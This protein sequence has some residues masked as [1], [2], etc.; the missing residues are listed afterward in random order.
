MNREIKEISISE[1]IEAIKEFFERT[2]PVE[3]NYLRD[4]LSKIDMTGV[5][6]FMFYWHV[7]DSMRTKT[8]PA[9]GVFVELY[10]Q[11]SPASSKKTGNE[12][13]TNHNNIEIERWKKYSNRQIIDIL[14]S[15]KGKKSENYSVGDIHFL[16]IYGDIYSEMCILSEIEVCKE[17]IRERLEYIRG[18][19]E[20]GLPYSLTKK[21]VGYI[22]VPNFNEARKI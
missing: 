11:F 5:E 22:N 21:N 9:H 1:F 19:I 17:D 14:K 18:R 15:I 16:N 12:S 8:F 6:L 20:K 3:L 2:R 4:W 13:I 10:K 7:V